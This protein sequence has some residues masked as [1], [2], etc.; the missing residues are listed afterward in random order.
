M[1]EYAL[2]YI[3]PEQFRIRMRHPSVRPPSVLRCW[4]ASNDR[5]EGVLRISL[6]FDLS[7]ATRLSIIGATGG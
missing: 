4:I 1:Y 3:G 7:I 6:E 5:R 2:L